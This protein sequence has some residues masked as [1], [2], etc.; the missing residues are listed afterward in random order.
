MRADATVFPLVPRHRVI[1]LA[2]GAVGS[3]RRGRGF[4]VAGSRPYVPGD[5][6]QSIDW[7]ASARLATARGSDDFVVLERYAEEAPRAVIV[8]DR[9][10]AMALY[11]ADS[12]WLSK[13]AAVRAIV[14]LIA[15]S[16][17]AAHG[18][19]GYL[20]LAG[21]HGATHP[22][23]SAARL[24]ELEAR[25]HEAPF[26][27]P[28]DNLE[29]ALGRV[30]DLGRDLPAGSFVFVISDFLEQPSVEAWSQAASRRWEIVPVVVQDPDW[31]QDFP[32]VERV[33]VP[34]VDPV[35]G[36]RSLVRLGREEVAR[37]RAENRDRRA[38]LLGGFDAQ[39]LTP[40]LVSSSDPEEILQAF[41]DWN[42]RRTSSDGRVW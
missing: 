11:P 21:E 33:V 8:C 1:G 15:R 9:R 40:V 13:P 41:L 25:M 3:A 5:P 10:P 2:F 27:A 4:D 36:R 30:R 22:P 29:R 32:A 12:P 34:L 26:D 37:R 23:R 16:T 31:E 39:A 6:V 28:P 14:E 20:D 17:A 19:L 38:H 35:S 18:L 7:K 24:D 42:E